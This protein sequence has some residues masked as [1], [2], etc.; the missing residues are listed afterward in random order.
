MVGW[1]LPR[2]GTPMARRLTRYG[3]SI[4]AREEAS[5]GKSQDVRPCSSRAPEGYVPSAVTACLSSPVGTQV[6]Y[7]GYR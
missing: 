3:Q 6:H 5:I 2:C 7:D 4:R 1:G